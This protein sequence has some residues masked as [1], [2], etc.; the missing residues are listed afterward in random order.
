MSV[1]RIRV[2]AAICSTDRPAA[3]RA[4]RSA[5]PREAPSGSA[6]SGTASPP[7][8]W[9][10]VVTQNGRNSPD[11]SLRPSLYEELTVPG[12]SGARKQTVKDRPDNGVGA[13]GAG[14]KRS[15]RERGQHRLELVRPD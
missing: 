2:S 6:V 14:L 10:H 7:S 11:R 3:S 13:A 1:P 12:K 9:P 5:A 15:A 4:A 8:G